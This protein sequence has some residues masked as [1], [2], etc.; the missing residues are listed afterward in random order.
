MLSEGFVGDL[1]DA[2]R[3]WDRRTVGRTKHLR[4]DREEEAILGLRNDMLNKV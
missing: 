2:L 3:S 4:D 1:V